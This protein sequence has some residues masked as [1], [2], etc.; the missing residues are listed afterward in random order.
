MSK[1][2][3]LLTC[4]AEHMDLASGNGGNLGLVWNEIP[5]FETC[6]GRSGTGERLSP[7]IGKEAAGSDWMGMGGCWPGCREGR[8]Q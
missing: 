6:G 7:E 2:R 5:V 3:A 4:K 8:L 1:W